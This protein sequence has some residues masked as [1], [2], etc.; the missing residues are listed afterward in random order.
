[1]NILRAIIV[2]DE[3]SGI[4]TLKILLEN[5]FEG[6]KVVA[7][8]TDGAK[9]IEMIE[10][11]RPEIVFLDVNMPN[12]DGFQLLEKLVYRDFYLIFVTAH[13]EHA[14]RAI[15]ADAVDYLLKPIDADDLALAINKSRKQL[16]EKT[17]MPDISEL[18]T[19]TRYKQKI[20]FNI[21]EKVE[22]VSRAQIL[23]LEADSNYTHVHLLDGEI[24]TVAKTIGEYEL[25]LC[26]P[27]SEFMRVHQS[28]IINLHHVI[29]YTRE[30]GGTIILKNNQQV[31]L[32]KT[33]KTEFI[34]W[35]NVS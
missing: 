18:A 3:P 14:L 35:L 4:T 19:L 24:I 7:H 11:Y 33:K 2:D 31:S 10:N 27:E 5:Y 26:L 28:H 9:A 21:R 15:K 22:Y 23:R 25:L 17:A 13:E 30:H 12:M 29:R 20:P 1:M 32:S 6:I 8:S 16:L 34:K